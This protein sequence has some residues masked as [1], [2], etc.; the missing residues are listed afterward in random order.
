MHEPRPRRPK[1]TSRQ[2]RQPAKPEEEGPGTLSCN[3]RPTK[4]V[5]PDEAASPDD[6]RGTAGRGRAKGRPA[7]RSGQRRPRGAAA[8]NR[9]RRPVARSPPRSLRR[10]QSRL[11]QA[12][13]S[14][15]LR[16][17]PCRRSRSRSRAP[18]CRATIFQTESISSCRRRAEFPPLPRRLRARVALPPPRARRTPPP[19][20]RR[21]PLRSALRATA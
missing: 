7:T 20:R 4:Q 6:E 14:V 11:R 9:R 2:A 12:R 21:L 3:G 19:R 15:R 5:K 10:Q 16:P 8:M 1:P 18:P 13:T 17:L